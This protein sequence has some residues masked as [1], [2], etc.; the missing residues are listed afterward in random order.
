MNTA[1]QARKA[2]YS[3]PGNV[4]RDRNGEA[5]SWPNVNMFLSSG[6]RNPERQERVGTAINSNHQ[7]GNAVDFSIRDEDFDSIRER[8][9]YYQILWEAS[10]NVTANLKQLE[11]NGVSVTSGDNI[12]IGLDVRPQNGLD[13]AFESADHLHID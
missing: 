1:Y 6:Y 7:L 5:L 4:L 9:A 10:G 11:D 13:D 8:A 12:R 2:H 3:Q